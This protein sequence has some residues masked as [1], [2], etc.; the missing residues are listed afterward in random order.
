MTSLASSSSFCTLESPLRF[1]EAAASS[2]FASVAA[3]AF[4][5]AAALAAA[6]AAAFSLP[7]LV[8]LFL[9]H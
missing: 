9:L 1:P 4:S 5:F 3:V 2:A 8:A 7:Q 6:F